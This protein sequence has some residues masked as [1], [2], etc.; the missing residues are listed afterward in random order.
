MDKENKFLY[1]L[2]S[3]QA[4]AGYKSHQNPAFFK[5]LASGQSPSIC[6]FICNAN[7]PLK[8]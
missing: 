4:W 3:N 6:K 7:V 8:L 5:N 1:A 2:S